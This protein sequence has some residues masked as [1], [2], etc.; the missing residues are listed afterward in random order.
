MVMLRSHNRLIELFGFTFPALLFGF[1]KLRL[2]IKVKLN[3]IA[4]SH[5]NDVVEKDQPERLV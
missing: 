3:M 1:W 2:H 4:D 5:I